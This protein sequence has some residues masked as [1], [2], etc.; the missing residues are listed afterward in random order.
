[1]IRHT[2]KG[3]DQN[4][5]ALS[6]AHP[7]TKGRNVRR[8]IRVNPA[9]VATILVILFVGGSLLLSTSGAR[10][11]TTFVVN[12]TGA[13]ADI[14]SQDGAC[15]ADGSAAGNQCTLRAA[16]QEANAATG[17]DTIQF[18]MLGDGARDSVVAYNVV[19][20]A[21]RSGVGID[22]AGVAATDG[23]PTT[24][25]NKVYGNRIGVS[26]GGR[27]LPTGVAGIQV[28]A[29]AANSQIGPRNVIANNR[30]GVRISKSQ[31]N[32]ITSNSIYANGGLGIDLAPIGRANKNDHLDP[33]EGA[34]RQQN[35]PV[36]TSAITSGGVSILRGTLD[37][38]RNNTFRIEFFSNPTG[39]G[40]GRTFVGYKNVTTGIDGRASFVFRPTMVVSPGRTVTATAT[41][42]GGNTSEF[43]A[44]RTVVKR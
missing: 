42:P 14:A 5:W 12:S 3:I 41:N 20:S 30:A 18:G 21:E 34:N 40:E 28:L 19:G 22:G 7:L 1:M 33:D 44:S 24:T 36:V 16:I 35:V 6:Y 8:T 38:T 4:G 15:D 11:E 10:A 23:S 2:A 27:A 13:S 26:R 17:A 39:N 31:A 25:G 29:G 32:R 9:T 37:S 43:S